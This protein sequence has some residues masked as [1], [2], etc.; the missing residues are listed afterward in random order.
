MKRPNEKDAS[1]FMLGSRRVNYKILSSSGNLV[2]CPWLTCSILCMILQAAG[3]YDSRN[4]SFFL[5]DGKHRYHGK[6]P[7]FWTDICIVRVKV[8]NNGTKGES[9]I[10][11]MGDILQITNHKVPNTLSERLTSAPFWRLVFM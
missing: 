11:I 6:T 2:D 5:M 7:S 4:W 10:K 8:L 1:V 9:K 3:C